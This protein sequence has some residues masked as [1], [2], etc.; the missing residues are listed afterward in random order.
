M[1]LVLEEVAFVEKKDIKFIQTFPWYIIEEL[2]LYDPFRDGIE[3]FYR[4]DS[5]N[6]W[7]TMDTILD[8]KDLR[9]APKEELRQK[10]DLIKKKLDIMAKDYLDATVEH[11]LALDRNYGRR[12]EQKK[13][14]Y[15][16]ETLEDYILN[17]EKYSEM[18]ARYL[19]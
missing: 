10:A 4:Y 7:A 6:Y 16:Y 2:N 12:Q 1:K 5:I 9:R 3:V 19:R 18:F 14:R 11:R 13:L 17:P 8:Y 15:I